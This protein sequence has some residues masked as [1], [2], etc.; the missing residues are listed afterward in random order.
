[1][2]A[3]VLA[4][5]V[6]TAPG[7]EGGRVE[8][9][10][11]QLSTVPA[12]ARNVSGGAPMQYR[13]RIGNRTG[14]T[15]T[16][17]QIQIQSVGEGAYTVGPTTRPF[18][19]Q[20]PPSEFREVELFV[21]AELTGGTISGANGPVSLRLTLFFQSSVGSFQETVIRQ[22]HATSTSRGE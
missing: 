19:T 5:C 9:D 18:T 2:A 10:L 17:E 15:V 6:S 1:M 7:T 11:V 16:L 14:E 13:V 20:I 12:A 21:P 8:V 22:A 3:L 4:A